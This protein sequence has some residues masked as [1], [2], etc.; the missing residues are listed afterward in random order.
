MAAGLEDKYFKGLV[1]TETVK[2]AVVS[3]LTPLGIHPIVLW[4]FQS[5]IRLRQA[6][7]K[8]ERYY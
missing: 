4:I 3:E 1:I 7:K 6:Q 2:R 8:Y 5:G